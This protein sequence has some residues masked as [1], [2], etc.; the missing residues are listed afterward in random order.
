MIISNKAALKIKNTQAKITKTTKRG[1]FSPDYS[2]SLS[3]IIIIN[4]PKD[5]FENEKG[6][7]DS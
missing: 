1:C 6:I 4:N 7:T 2:L 3:L 5:I